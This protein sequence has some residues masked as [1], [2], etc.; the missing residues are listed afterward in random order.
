MDLS[1]VIPALNEEQKIAPDITSAAFF[2]GEAGLS[3]EVIVVDDGSTDRTFHNALTALV[4]EAVRRRV[5]RL[6]RNSGKGFAVKTGILESAGD[7]V[8]YAD[9]GT[10]IPY[11]DALPSVARMRAGE[12]DMALG[13][14]THKETVICRNRPFM[15]Q[16]ISRLFRRASILF[17]G[18][19]RDIRDSQCGF[20]LYQ[21]D[22][23][24]ELF[25]GLQTSGF[26]FE[27]EVIMKARRA[28]WRLEE[29]PVHWSCDLDT[30]LRPGRQAAGVFRQLL[31]VRKI[32]R[33][34]A[35]RNA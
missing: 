18:L 16:I 34:P 6:D 17:V 31:R 25:A 5:I 23:A 35:P 7:I 13:S 9:S 2:L 26:L 29:F 21:G 15:R 4:P 19:P 24:R 20:K 22:L 3:G 12:L 33:T 14:R 32:L 1:I 28:G 8:L 27:L 11:A 10:C 30:R